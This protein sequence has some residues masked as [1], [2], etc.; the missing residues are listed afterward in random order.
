MAIVTVIVMIAIIA[1]PV[2]LAAAIVALVIVHRIG[3]AAGQANQRGRK[4][5]Q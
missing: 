4:Q 1:T 3:D 5:D 2:A